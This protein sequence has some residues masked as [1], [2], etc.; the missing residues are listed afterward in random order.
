MAKVTAS[1]GDLKKVAQAMGLEWKTSSEFNRSGTVEGVAAGAQLMEAFS[2]DVGAVFG[3]VAIAD[4]RF[5]CKVV[6]KISPDMS[7]LAQDREMLT[8]EIKRLKARER[9][10]LFVDGI[11][12]TLIRQGKVKIHQKVVDRLV[13]SYR[14]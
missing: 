5:I 8:L 14:G 7:Q 6:A 1:G 2:K 4:R 9:S 13:T 3:P 11:R 10:D 12:T